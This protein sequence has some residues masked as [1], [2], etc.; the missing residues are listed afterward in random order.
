MGFLVLLIGSYRVWRNAARLVPNLAFDAQR[1]VDA[2]N[3]FVRSRD[4]EGNPYAVLAQYQANVVQA[5]LID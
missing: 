3:A 2:L 1:R 4:A 5:A